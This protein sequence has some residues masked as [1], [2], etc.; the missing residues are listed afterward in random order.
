MFNLKNCNQPIALRDILIGMYDREGANA[1]MRELVRQCVCC[2][3][4]SCSECETEV[5]RRFDEGRTQ[6]A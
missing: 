2:A 1:G 4:P 6:Q 3:S 5:S